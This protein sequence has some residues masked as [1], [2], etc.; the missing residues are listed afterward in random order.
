VSTMRVPS[1]EPSMGKDVS[2]NGGNRRHLAGIGYVCRH[3]GFAPSTLEMKVCSA[4]RGEMNIHPLSE[5]AP[6]LRQASAW[7]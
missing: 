5:G 4:R 7:A 3:V 6:S 2:L 1:A